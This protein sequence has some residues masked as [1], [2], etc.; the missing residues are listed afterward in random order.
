MRLPVFATVGRSYVQCLRN[1][2]LVAA[3]AAVIWIFLV[4]TV[5]SFLNVFG[6]A[7]LIVGDAEQMDR[8]KERMK[9]LSNYELI[10]DFV[11]WAIFLL[12]LTPF[13]TAWHRRFA[14]GRIL[15]PASQALR[16][17]KLQV[18]VFVQLIVLLVVYFVT[19]ALAIVAGLILGAAIGLALGE[20]QLPSSFQSISFQSNNPFVV[21]PPVLLALFIIVTVSLRIWMVIPARALEHQLGLVGSWK[22]MRGNT[23]RMFWIFIFCMLIAYIPMLVIGLVF[24]NSELA[25]MVFQ[26][27]AF[28]IS[29][30]A[31]GLIV[32][33]LLYAWLTGV[34][35]SVLSIAYGRLT[36]TPLA[37][38]GQEGHSDPQT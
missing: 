27:S 16:F 33:A 32:A 2:D 19:F 1:W 4:A 29:T 8:A 37:P 36:D 24:I 12:L 5:W 31:I 15:V 7:D 21:V 13:A 3:H 9:V 35:L 38:A 18:S 14:L 17:G 20:F 25:L 11:W 6:M 22:L 23:I 30:I 10:F 26:P 28:G 34:I